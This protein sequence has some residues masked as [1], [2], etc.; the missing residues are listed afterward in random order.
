SPERLMPSPEGCSMISRLPRLDLGYALRAPNV[1]TPGAGETQGNGPRKNTRPWRG[2]TVDPFRV[3][4][5]RGAMQFP[6]LRLLIDHR[7]KLLPHLAGLGLGLD[8]V[9]LA[10]S[11]AQRANAQKA[12]V[13][14]A[15][16]QSITHRR[17]SLESSPS[18]GCPDQISRYTESQS[19]SG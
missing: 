16:A 8:L 1:E 6:P 14:V 5:I 4:T 10:Q 18:T 17:D 9:A 19:G 12:R 2:R 15:R 3:G 7:V 13:L 11:S